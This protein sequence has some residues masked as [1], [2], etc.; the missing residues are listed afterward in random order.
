MLLSAKIPLPTSIFSHGFINS[1]GQKMSKSIGNVIDPLELVQKY[2]VDSTRYLLLRHVHPTEDTDVTWER[3]DE[4]YTANLVNGLGNLVA[5]VMKL[6]EDHLESP[7]AIAPEDL[8]IESGFTTSLNQFAFT[9]AADLIWE[10]IARGDEYMTERAPYKAIKE[11]ETKEQAKE[12]ITKLVKHVAKVAAHLQ[13]L[14]PT[15][16]E[17]ILNAVRENKKPENLFPRLA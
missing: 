5:R 12:D 7:V 1:G 4:W 8:A 15:T 17:L 9:E 10:H 16:S 2:G 3:L 11:E 13:P 14:M 6:A